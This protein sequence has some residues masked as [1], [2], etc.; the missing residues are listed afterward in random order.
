MR[1]IL[2]VL[3]LVLAGCATQENTESIESTESIALPIVEKLPSEQEIWFETYNMLNDT[4]ITNNKGEPFWFAMEVEDFRLTIDLNDSLSLPYNSLEE[5]N[6][7]NN[8]VVDFYHRDSL[9]LKGEVYSIKDYEVRIRPY[10]FTEHEQL[11]GGNRGSITIRPNSS[12]VRLSLHH[13]WSDYGGQRMSSW[14]L[15]P[16]V[17]SVWVYVDEVGTLRY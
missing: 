13:W 9:I 5:R 10:D 17:D 16:V 3:I 12:S 11:A 15:N 1:N 7:L 8:T 6:S 4:S 2:F 14:T